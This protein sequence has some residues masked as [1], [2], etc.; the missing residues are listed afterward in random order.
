MSPRGRFQLVIDPGQLD[1]LRMIQ[2]TNGAP[3]STQIRKA[4]DTYL[5]T[6]TVLSKKELKEVLGRASSK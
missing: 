5:Q 6:Q 3:V 4:I 2:A 1:A